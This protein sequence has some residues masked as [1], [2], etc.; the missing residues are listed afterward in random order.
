MLTEQDLNDLRNTKT[1]HEWNAICDRVKTSHG[2]VYP[3]DWFM[4]VL[5]S[6][7]AG[8]ASRRWTR[9]SMANEK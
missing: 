2:G 3:A 8:D 5:A 9:L 7:L 1:E 6:G 4:K